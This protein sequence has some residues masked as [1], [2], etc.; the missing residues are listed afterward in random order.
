ML[1]DGPINGD[2][3]EACTA[4][5]RRAYHRERRQLLQVVQL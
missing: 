5:N 4:Q 1:L 2:W 3:F